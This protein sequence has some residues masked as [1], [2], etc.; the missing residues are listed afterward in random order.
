MEIDVFTLKRELSLFLL[1]CPAGG[2][3]VDD[4]RVWQRKANRNG[5]ERRE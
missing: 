3:Y 5:G 2:Q 1:P 4:K